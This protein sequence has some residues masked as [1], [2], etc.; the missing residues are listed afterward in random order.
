MDERSKFD[1]PYGHFGRVNYDLLERAW[2]FGRTLSVGE[3]FKPL[4][5]V[6]K[7]VKPPR[8]HGNSS[9]NFKAY[10]TTPEPPNKRY[11]RQIKS[12]VQRHPDFHAAADLLAPL[13]KVSEA[14]EAAIANH[15]PSRGSLVSFMQIRSVTSH[16]PVSIVAYASGETGCVLRLAR[17]LVEKRGL[18]GD[19]TSWLEIPSISGE[20]TSA[21]PG[22][23]IQ[24][25]KF[26]TSSGGRNNFLAV[27]L[28]NKITIYQP[29]VGAAISAN[30][31]GSSL[32]LNHLHSISTDQGLDQRFADVAFNPWFPQQ[33]AIA[34]CTGN[35]RVLEFASSKLERV[36][37]AWSRVETDRDADDQ[38]LTDGWVRIAWVGSLETLVVCTRTKVRLCSI[39]GERVETLQE[40][41]VQADGGGASVWI[42]DFM[43]LPDDANHFCLVTS[44]CV[45]IYEIQTD[46]STGTSCHVQARIRHFR[47][48][49]DLSLR[50]TSWTEPGS[51]RVVLYSSAYSW[52]SAYRCSIPGYH[53]LL[54]EDPIILATNA[55]RD[56]PLNAFKRD[57]HIQPLRVI[58]NPKSSAHKDA[59]A[60]QLEEQ[61]RFYIANALREDYTISQGIWQGSSSVDTDRSRLSV[62]LFPIKETVRSSSKLLKSGFIVDDDALEIGRQ[63]LARREPFARRTRREVLQ[64][65][66]NNST[67]N[68]EL[69]A[70]ALS[71]PVG[72]TVGLQDVTSNVISALNEA[73]SA[74]TLPLQTLNNF[75]K[76][77]IMAGDM[78]DASQLLED[79]FN[80]GSNKADVKTAIDDELS[81]LRNA[82]SDVHLPDVTGL[83]EELRGVSLRSVYDS[84]ISRWISSLPPQVP[85][86]VRLAKVDIVSRAA[87]ELVLAS[88][89]IRVQDNSKDPVKEEVDRKGAP[90]GQVWELPVR[91]SVLD[92]SYKV[93]SSPPTFEDDQKVP[94]LPT[95]S[96]T[97]TPSVITA[98][99]HSSSFAAPELL[100]LSRYTTFTKPSPSVLPRSISNVLSHWKP[101]EDLDEYDWLSTARHI[102]QKDDDGMD[103]EMT[104]RDRKRIQKRAERHIRRQR[105]EAA[106]SQAQR[107]ASSQ[108]AEIF[109][110]SQPAVGK[111]ETQSSG[112]AGSSQSQRP[113][114]FAAS[115][116]VPGRFGGGRPPSKKRRKHG[117]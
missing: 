94:L 4:K 38:A 108:A 50:L 37:R 117:F 54:A 55:D 115:Q 21:S 27:R 33:V 12:L 77:E 68:I 39:A 114:A 66:L 111:F 44:Q 78:E 26:G 16:K 47:N 29:V 19:G 80:T 96:P 15:D 99:S 67:I 88:R 56:R 97:A 95:P 14:V 105:K 70:S 9:H 64:R 60:M 61:A 53:Q 57:L 90:S 87:A 6:L 89:M 42:L 52:A 109:S 35:W 82:M 83:G 41:D 30:D 107:L 112:V 79:L 102:S 59:S 32:R 72:D 73:V 74:V 36:A 101:G 48:P 10:G 17:V 106:A 8:A 49:E 22:G 1:L 103:E 7:D 2:T 91:S 100:R 69:I 34:D 28:C 75:A 98:S 51:L 113:A 86:W 43:V 13:L 65:D 92:S 93:D 62:E 25:V 45:I 85:G 81:H 11:W 20:E 40:I 24:Q 84:L 46:T 3:S 71:A 5:D 23:P 58:R 76:F 63:H 18:D 104:E 116:V 31:D 110:A